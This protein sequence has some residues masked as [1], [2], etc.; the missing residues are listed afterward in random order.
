M[1][2]LPPTHEINSLSYTGQYIRT[3]CSSRSP[4]QQYK[5]A[6]HLPRIGRSR[7]V[8]VLNK[9]RP[10]TMNYNVC[11]WAKD[12]GPMKVEIAEQV[13]TEAEWAISAGRSL[14]SRLQRDSKK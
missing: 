7:L 2:Q 4:L 1:M 11:L 6:A 8:P 14:S 3:A 13:E 5:T 9:R 12:P 10:S